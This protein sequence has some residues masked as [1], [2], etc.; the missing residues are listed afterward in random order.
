LWTICLGW[1]WTSILLIS[2]SWIAR[3]TGVRHWWPGLAW[4]FVFSIK[5]NM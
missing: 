2:A 3:I 1:L 5:T 4:Y